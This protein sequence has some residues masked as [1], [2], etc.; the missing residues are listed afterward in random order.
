MIGAK[1][2]W[3]NLE[4]ELASLETRPEAC[5]RRSRLTEARADCHSCSAVCP[6]GAIDL[7]PLS[8]DQDACDG[9]GACAE[10]CPSSALEH[11]SSFRRDLF[12]ALTR[13]ERAKIF[14]IACPLAE[15]SRDTV[16]VE[17]P[18]VAGMPWE[19][20]VVALLRGASTV[21]VVTGCC[22]RCSRQALE[23]QVRTTI[24]AASRAAEV[25]KLG[26]VT[27]REPGE[28]PLEERDPSRDRRMSRRGLWDG[29]LRGGKHVMER[30]GAQGVE[31]LARVMDPR[32]GTDATRDG[33]WLRGLLTKALP[34]H[35][36]AVEPIELPRVGR[37]SV[38]ASA[39]APCP[40]CAAACPSQALLV[41]LGMRGHQELSVEPERCTACGACV[42]ACPESAVTLEPLADLSGWGRRRILVKRR[43]G[44]CLHCGESALSI[45]LPYCAS[46]YREGHANGHLPR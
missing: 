36:E 29:L 26:A 20:P 45:E 1:D 30:V 8:L 9:C 13:V 43:P 24:D 28:V 17:L 21:E 41:K 32:A 15:D 22:E 33:L 14:R 10:V 23:P 25:L 34:R 31:R 38:D 2:V 19:V 42:V 12:V 44:A 39:C 18:C 40:L 4:E 3:A 6:L 37:L 46:C 7:E 11:A 5:L 35:G 16:R 27:R